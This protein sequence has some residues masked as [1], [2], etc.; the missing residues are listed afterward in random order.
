MDSTQSHQ[1]PFPWLNPVAQQLTQTWQS[2]RFHHAMLFE[3]QQ[4]IGKFALSRWLANGF[5]CQ[6]PQGPH[7]TQGALYTQ[8]LGACGQC[9]S[10]LLFNAGNHPDCRTIDNDNPSIGV[11]DIRQATAFVYSKSQIAQRRVLLINKAEKLTEAAANALLKTLEEPCANVFILLSCDDRAKLLPTITSRCFKMLVTA[12]DSGLV[13]QWLVNQVGALDEA[14]FNQLYTLSNKAPLKVLEWLQ[15]NKL[16][17]VEQFTGQFGQWLTGNL[18]NVV[19]KNAL[20]GNAFTLLLFH[21]LLIN[22]LRTR[23]VNCHEVKRQAVNAGQQFAAVQQLFD[24][25]S[26]FS[27]DGLQIL[28]QNKSLALFT[29]LN[30]V[31]SCIKDIR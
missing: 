17:E 18:S 4:G 14:T 20:E 21:H 5:M 24:Q 25:M 28:G 15:Q 13:Y 1:L 3:G 12:T 6:N 22:H 29:L 31:A 10:C 19:L 8:G 9:K 11:D 2:G 23:L 16:A 30:Q 27:R 7:D 26:Q